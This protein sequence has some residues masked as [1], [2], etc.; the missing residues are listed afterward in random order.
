MNI[1]IVD[2]KFYQELV[3]NN[4]KPVFVYIPHSNFWRPDKRDKKYL[5]IVSLAPEVF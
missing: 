4:C 5:K 1:A 2:E 3:K